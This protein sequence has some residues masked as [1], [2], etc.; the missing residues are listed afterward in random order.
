M[1]QETVLLLGNSELTLGEPF[2]IVT[3][4]RSNPDSDAPMHV[5]AEGPACADGCWLAIRHPGRVRRLVLT[6]PECPDDELGHR[7]GEIHAETLVVL[8]TSAPVEAGQIYQQ[9]IPRA[10]RFFVYAPQR[11]AGL[12]ADF[13]RRGETFIVNTGAQTAW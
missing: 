2:R 11:C 12:I 7:L 5:V 9:R 6:R 8:D 1:S 10:Y 3:P 4:S 13:L